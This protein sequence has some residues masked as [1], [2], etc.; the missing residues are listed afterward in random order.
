MAESCASSPLNSN[1]PCDESSSCARSTN[2][3]LRDNIASE[4]RQHDW[5]VLTQADDLRSPSYEEESDVFPEENEIEI[6]GS[7][8]PWFRETESTLEHA[9]HTFSG[10]VID[11]RASIVDDLLFEIYDRWQDTR[12]DSFDSDFTE[13]SSTSEFFHGRHSFGEVEGRN[14]DKLHRA[15]LEV[16]NEKQLRSMFSELQHRINQTNIRLVRQLKRRDRR[17]AKLQHNCDIVTAI[18]QASSLKRRID[19]RIRFALEPPPGDNTFEQWKDAMKAVARLP[20]GIPDEF[21]KKFWINLADHHIRGLKIDW[22][23]TV[24]LAFNEKS[25]PDDN[26]L[27]MQIVKDL[28]RT[29]CSGFSGQDNEEDRAILKRVLLAYAR[30]NKRVGYCQGFNV[31]AALLLEVMEC[32]E[33]EA[34]KVMIYLIDHVL[35]E[36]YFANNL[37]ALSV[38][39]AVFRD[40]LRLTQPSLSKHLDHLQYAAQDKSTGSCYEPPLTNVFTMQWFLTLFATCLPKKTV[41]RVWDSILLEGSEILLRTALVI[42][43]KLSSRIMSVA[44]ADE[45]YTLMGDLTQDMLEGRTFDAD[46]MIKVKSSHPDA[47]WAKKKLVRYIGSVFSH[48][49]YVCTAAHHVFGHSRSRKALNVNFRECRTNLHS[50]SGSQ[51]V[52]WQDTPEVGP[53]EAL[54]CWCGPKLCWEHACIHGSECAMTKISAPS[55]NSIQNLERQN[56]AHIIL[57][58]ASAKHR[59]KT[60]A[61]VPRIETPGAVNHLFVGKQLVGGKN[62]YITE[63]PRI[64]QIYPKSKFA[65]PRHTPL[66]I[67]KM[68]A[69]FTGSPKR[70]QK[71]SETTKNNS[72]IPSS[73][74]SSHSIEKEE[75]PKKEEN[76]NNTEEKPDND[77]SKQ[78]V[79]GQ[80]IDS[81][82]DVSEV[83]NKDVLNTGESDPTERSENDL[84]V[85]IQEPQDLR[86]EVESSE[87]VISQE[88]NCEGE[89][90]VRGVSGSLVVSDVDVTDK[91]TT[92]CDDV[93]IIPNTGSCKDGENIGVCYENEKKSAKIPEDLEDSELSHLETFPETCSRQ[94]S[95]DVCVENTSSFE[96]V[97]ECVDIANDTRS[98]GISV[99]TMV[100]EGTTSPDPDSGIVISS[101]FLSTSEPETEENGEEIQVHTKEKIQTSSQ[102]NDD[103]QSP[104]S[105]VSD[106]SGNSNCSS[107]SQESSVLD[108]SPVRERS[109]SLGSPTS[110]K[111]IKL[112][113]PLSD[114]ETNPLPVQLMSGEL[115]YIDTSN[116]Q[117][118]KTR[119][120]SVAQP[121]ESDVRNRIATIVSSQKRDRRKSESSRKSSSTFQNGSMRNMEQCHASISPTSSQKHFNPFP[122]H[123][124]NQNRAKT[125][126]KLGLYKQSALKR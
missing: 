106:T 52:V 121:S 124:V 31:I 21:R 24:R 75:S 6:I 15:V 125:G 42:W 8:Q 93:N 19:T 104:N 56:Q 63:G 39:M 13:C 37:R 85:E 82:G 119:S 84:N 55:R 16:Q 7:L 80:G 57:A 79:L 58:A 60:R 71:L 91:D 41:L 103:L 97:V 18:L 5:N 92:V 113:S 118:H 86:K 53:Q 17:L 107:F 54:W 95:K 116:V 89:D 65:G 61:I 81:K 25:N 43:G 59:A 29:G 87:L 108:G 12:R 32:Q 48:Q 26:K 126:V 72:Q 83:D 45:F 22:S 78:P 94:H 96:S 105:T 122:V 73:G 114:L 34:L 14:S 35:P 9:N 74:K 10:C 38:D 88:K 117:N 109:I 3:T 77:T 46:A 76:K 120:N 40:L 111:Q 11:R 68:S 90:N 33:D 98:S 20:L 112:N 4:F 110:G 101:N 70:L 102:I 64:A 99:V 30:W 67:T 27:G 44:S 23:R 51:L 2:G 62:R 50:S 28:H 1:F 69:L 36:S 100:E 47:M 49:I 115:K 66:G 123:H